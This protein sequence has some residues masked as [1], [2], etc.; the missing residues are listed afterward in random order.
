M[1]SVS[2]Y[3]MLNGSNYRQTYHNRGTEVNNERNEVLWTGASQCRRVP[4]KLEYM[5]FPE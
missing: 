5:M 3:R 2:L 1:E 4:F